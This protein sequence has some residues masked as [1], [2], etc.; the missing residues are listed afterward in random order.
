[1]PTTIVCISAPSG[2]GKTTIVQQLIQLVPNSV[3][4][5]FDD[6][7]E[8][9]EGAN[10]HPVDLQQWLAAGA[11]Y[12]AWQMPG[13][14]R[15]LQQLKG[16]QALSLRTGAMLSAP[17]FVWL[18][19]AIGRANATLQ[20]YID[21]MVFIDTPL[22]VAMARRIQRDYGDHSR[23]AAHAQLEQLHTTTSAYLTWARDAYLELGRQVKPRSDL[24]LDGCLAVD[25]LVAYILN[26]LQ[27]TNNRNAPVG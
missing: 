23:E 22:D 15:D 21:F 26:H 1:M 6:Y 7:D 27:P 13:L 10:I 20:P 14:I 18:D 11:D 3:A 9:A 2:G 16:G 8:R 24:V 17:A 25:V 12:N 4:L 19:A 5:Y